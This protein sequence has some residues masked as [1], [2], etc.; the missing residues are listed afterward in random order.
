MDLCLSGARGLNEPDRKSYGANRHLYVC[1]KSA[2]C[3]RELCETMG[4]V[5]NYS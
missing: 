4:F 2:D 3:D 5:K 1:S